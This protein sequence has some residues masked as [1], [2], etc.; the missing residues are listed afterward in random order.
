MSDAVDLDELIPHGLGQLTRAVRHRAGRPGRS[1]RRSLAAA[2]AAHRR[3]EPVRHPGARARGVPDRLRRLAAPPST[4]RRWPG[5]RPSTRS[6]SSEMA[7][8]DRRR[9]ALG[10]R[11][12]G[13]RARCWTSC[14]TRAGAASRRPSARTRTWSAPSAPPTCAAWSRPGSS[15][16]SS[17]SPATPPP[18]A[19]RNLAP[20]VDRAAR[21]RRRDPAAVRDGAARGR[22]ALGDALLHRHRR[23]ARRRRPRAAHRAAARRL[24]LRRHRRR[25][26]LRHRVP[27][28]PARRRRDLGE[29]AGAALAAGI[30]V[31]LP[32]VQAV[33]R[34]AARGGRRRA[35]SP[36]TLVDRALRRVLRQKAELGLL[37][38]DWTRAAG[39]RRRR[40]LGRT[41]RGTVDL[42]PPR[43]A[44]WPAGSPSSRSC[45]CATTACCRCG[46][47]RRASPW[48]ARRRRPARDARLLLLPHPRRRAPPRRRRS[49]IEIPTLLEALRAEF[50]DAEI[51]SRGGTG[52]DGGDD[53][54]HRR[55]RRARPAPT[56]ASPC[57]ATGPGC[58]A[59]APRGEGCDAADLRLPGVQAELLDALLATG[60]PVVACCSPAARTRSAPRPDGAAA[61]VQA[62]FPG[63]EGAPR[64]RRRA[65]RPGQPVRPAAGQRARR[66]RRPA[67]APTSRRRSAGAATCRTST[68]PRCSRSATASPTHVRRGRDLVASGR[69][70]PRTARSTVR[71]H[72]AQHRRPRRRR[73]RAALPA[74]PGGL[75]DPPGAAADR[76]RPGGARRPATRP[77]RRSACPPTSPRSPAATGARIVEPGELELRAG[78][79]QRRRAVLAF[80]SRRRDGSGGGSTTRAAPTRRSEC[81]NGRSALERPTLSSSSPGS[82]MRRP[83]RPVNDAR[84]AG[85]VNAT[86]ASS[87]GA[88]STRA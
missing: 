20:V 75:G 72:R 52:V 67:V 24:G 70:G 17:T 69:D 62:F 76:L 34:A 73:G 59:A 10:R 27:A 61:V 63:E 53:R 6:W 39:A 31:E 44:R 28:D 1:A 32:T 64:G 33:R 74:R 36:R 79:V 46:R 56:C 23:R 42:D 8:P 84:S 18:R 7:A 14:A 47:H 30:D 45:C 12:P 35:R 11:P 43:T 78:R 37:D 80:A 15:P 60:T 29:A 41:L 16:P 3:R 49:G 22:R 25:R 85:T 87:P 54:R 48:S 38:P 5:A 13:P 9:H 51:A 65:H 4:R 55:G 66:P 57:S 88:S 40:R 77:R 19:G 21:A 58:S 2:A 50:P 68:R 86:R 83:S 81:E 71:L 26:L 82:T